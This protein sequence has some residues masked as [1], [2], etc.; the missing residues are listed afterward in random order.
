[1]NESLINEIAEAVIDEQSQLQFI[2]LSKAD[3]NF[4]IEKLRRSFDELETSDIIGIENGIKNMIGRTISEIIGSLNNNYNVDEKFF[5][6]IK[7]TFYGIFEEYYQWMDEFG[8]EKYLKIE[9]E[10]NSLDPHNF[11][12]ISPHSRSSASTEFTRDKFNE[13]M[14]TLAKE[15]RNREQSQ[16]QYFNVEL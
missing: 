13:V 4:I 14:E 10:I 2:N 11:E 5:F 9:A 1:M 15:Q 8:K 6:M 12:L 16:T 7:E 3:R